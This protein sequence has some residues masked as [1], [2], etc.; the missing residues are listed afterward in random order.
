MQ[1]KEKAPR[2]EGREETCLEKM[3]MELRQ[4]M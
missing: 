4:K 2:G 1:E 3:I